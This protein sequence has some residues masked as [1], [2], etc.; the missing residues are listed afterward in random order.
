LPAAQPQDILWVDTP[1]ITHTQDYFSYAPYTQKSVPTNWLAPVNHSEG[2]L[3]LHVEVISTPPGAEFPIYYTVTWQPGR[4]WSGKNAS[5]KGFLRA[6][7]EINKPGPAVYDAVADVRA[8]EY[9]PDGSCCQQVC[10]T[11]WPWDAAWQDIAG[12]V[13]VLKGRGFPLTVKTKL[14]LRPVL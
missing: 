14:V 10:D 2:K 4:A 5:A 3:W 1:S 9:S 12:D 13:V 8:T 6:S 7:V 11:A